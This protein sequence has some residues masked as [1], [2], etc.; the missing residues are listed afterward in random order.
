MPKWIK[1]ILGLLGMIVV[2]L[3]IAFL[4]FSESLPTGKTGS[5][6]EAMAN[7]MLTAINKPA[8][9]NNTGIVQWSFPG[10]HDFIWDKKRHLTEVK[11]GNNRTLI[12]LQKVTGKAYTDGNEVTGEA[13][14]ALVKEAWEYWCNDSFWLNAPAKVMDGGTERSVVDLEDGG[15]GLLVT[16]KGGGATP[17]DSYLWTLD[18]SGLPTNYKMWTSNIPVGGVSATWDDWQTLPTGAKIATSHTLS[19]GGVEIPI[20]NIKAATDLS[21]FG[22]TEDIFAPIL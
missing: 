9:D 10:G 11:W 3:G 15:K 6:A 20:T 17:G 12:D 2:A 22:M 14:A 16:Y 18:D 4:I 21:S 5:E 8:W 1:W 13:G 19:I 7:K